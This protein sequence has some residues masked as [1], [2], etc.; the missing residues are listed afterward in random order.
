MSIPRVL[1]ISGEAL[2]VDISAVTDVAQLQVKVAEVLHTATPCLSLVQ[3]CGKILSDAKSEDM[4]LGGDITAI[5]DAETHGL[6]QKW[7][8]SLSHTQELDSKI[9]A[10]REVLSQA[11][12]A[13]VHA[14]DVDEMIANCEFELQTSTLS[15]R[16]EKQIFA[17]LQWL[18]HAKSKSIAAKSKLIST[19]E[20]ARKDLDALYGQMRETRCEAERAREMLM[21]LRPDR[22]W[23]GL[24]H[25]WDDDCSHYD[26][27]S[28][29][30][31]DFFF[32]ADSEDDMD[33]HQ[34]ENHARCRKLKKTATKQIREPK[35]RLRRSGKVRPRGGRHKIGESVDL[36]M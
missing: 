11:F 1:L 31:S 30:G 2:D 21:S 32:P 22:V 34:W 24:L 6:Y 4:V 9:E 19:V 14:Q 20:A 25:P 10:K 18:R 28:D 29:F 16:R 33:Q 12:H 5:V 23:R 26:Y 36:E 8:R 17:Y 13:Q 15:L 35:A 7:K 27:G 3:G